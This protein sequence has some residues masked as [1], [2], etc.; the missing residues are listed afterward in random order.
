[1]TVT[2]VRELTL[3]YRGK[4]GQSFDAARSPALAAG[5]IRRVLPDN[6]REHFVALL[7]NVRQEVVGFYVVATGGAASCPVGARE[8]FQAAV[9]AG[10]TG[11]V[12]GHN[13]PS[14]DPTPSPEDRTV[15]QR[16]K[17]AGELLGIPIV[18]HLIIGGERFYSLFDHGEL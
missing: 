17:Q 2:Y 6:V 14:G 3:R 4:K 7:L 8:I 10:A 11:L 1:M 16:L 12:L 5:L 9:V 18:D 15:T 13:H